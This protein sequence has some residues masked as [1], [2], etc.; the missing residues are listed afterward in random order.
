MTPPNSDLGDDIPVWGLEANGLYSVKSG[1]ALAKGLALDVDEKLWNRIWKWD[2]SQRIRQFMWLAVHD[3]LLTNAERHRRHL[4]DSADCGLCNGTTETCEHI[5]RHCPM[6][7]QEKLSMSA[8]EDLRRMNTNLHRKIEVEV[9]WKAAGYPS[10]TLNTDGSVLR[11]T[12]VAAAGGAIR[13]W[14]GRTIDA[15][16]AN[17]GSC[18]ITRAELTSIVIVSILSQESPSD[19]QHAALVLQY[20]RLKERSWTTNLIHIFREA[21][22]LADALASKGTTLD[23]GTIRWIVTIAR[24]DIGSDMTFSEERK[25]G[26][27]L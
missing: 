22:H 13:N 14:Q 1:Y 6:A 19:H 5:L 16:T 27:L 15:F 11:T 4:A 3:R 7:R 9:G 8:L 26:V 10:A 12:G 18:S 24:S 20:R 23:L 25:R 21:N 17:L 2:G